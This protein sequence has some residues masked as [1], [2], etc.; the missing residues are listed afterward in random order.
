MIA[1]SITHPMSKIIF[2]LLVSYL[3]QIPAVVGWW[4]SAAVGGGLAVGV[5]LS[6]M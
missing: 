6:P 1:V 2:C 4:P 3:A 5:R